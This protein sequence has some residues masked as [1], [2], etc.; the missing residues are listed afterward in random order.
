[1]DAASWPTP[2]ELI[3]VG[4]ETVPIRTRRAAALV[5]QIAPRPNRA[6]LVPAHTSSSPKNG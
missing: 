2:S 1:M 6:E 3:I 4:T 5:P